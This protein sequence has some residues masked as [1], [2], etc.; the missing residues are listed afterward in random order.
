MNILGQRAV[1]IER[2]V[3]MKT[4][5]IIHDNEKTR[6]DF[7]DGTVVRVDKGAYKDVSL[8]LTRPDKVQINLE[9]YS[10]AFVIE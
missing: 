3:S 4:I 1:R 9:A 7:P 2:A 5:L 8:W 10:I 6:Y